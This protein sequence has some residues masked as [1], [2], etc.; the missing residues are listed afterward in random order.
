MDEQSTLWNVSAEY[1]VRF[2]DGF[3]GGFGIGAH[4]NDPERN[5]VA[6]VCWYVC[7]HILEL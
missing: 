1:I 4:A 6:D 2:L 7:I 5:A 3:Q